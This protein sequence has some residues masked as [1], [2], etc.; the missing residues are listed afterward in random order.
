[1]PRMTSSGEEGRG[2]LLGGREVRP[3]ARMEV[4]RSVFRTSKGVL[5][6]V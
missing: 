4:R 5:G 2:V 1:M 3:V 6:E